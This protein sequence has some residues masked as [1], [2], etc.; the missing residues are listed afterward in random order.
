VR[1]KD[2]FSRYYAEWMAHFNNEPFLGSVQDEDFEGIAA[3]AGFDRAATV[4][5]QAPLRRREDGPDAPELST[6]LVVSAR[7]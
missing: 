7:K 1:P 3:G 5:A 4:V 6:F 2:L